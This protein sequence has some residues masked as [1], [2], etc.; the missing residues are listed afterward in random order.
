[1]S[2]LALI[3]EST[4]ADLAIEANDLGTDDGMETAVLLSLFLDRQA[5]PGDELPMG[6]T[7]RRGWWADA[8]P[9]VEGDEIGSRLWL[10][11]R[12]KDTATVRVRA[13]G[14]AREALEWLVEDRVAERVDVTASA[15]APGVLSLS[16]DIYR[17]SSAEPTRFRFADVWRAMEA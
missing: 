8:V 9:V 17:P 1:M 13:E 11:A 6:E 2:D 12:A 15:P 16:I 10:L 5:E 7:D 3:W 4:S 14:Y